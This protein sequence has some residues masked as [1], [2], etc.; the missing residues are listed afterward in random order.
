MVVVSIIKGA[1]RKFKFLG[2]AMRYAKTSADLVSSFSLK[3]PKHARLPSSET[4]IHNQLGEFMNVN[5]IPNTGRST[6][7][8]SLSSIILE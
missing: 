8:I 5:Y 6:P 1:V 7:S 4:T 3:D 2:D